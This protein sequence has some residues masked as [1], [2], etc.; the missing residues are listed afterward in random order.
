MLVWRIENEQG[1]GPYQATIG[2]WQDTDYY[3][4]DKPS[5]ETDKGFKDS[6]WWQLTE[7]ER[8]DWKFGFADLE[9]LRRWFSI[10][11]LI[12]LDIHGFRVAIYETNKFVISD[13]QCAFLPVDECPEEELEI[14]VIL[15]LSGLRWM[16]K[17][18]LS[19]RRLAPYV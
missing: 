18:W 1:D 4:D 6:V 13:Y 7:E 11:E 16:M 8:K 14:K 10:Q 15:G 5:P 19:R 12:N 2:P 3:Y 17:R 9:Q